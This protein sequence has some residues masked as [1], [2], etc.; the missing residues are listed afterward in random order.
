LHVLE[1][2]VAVAIATGEGEQDVDD[3][4][5]QRRHVPATDIP[6]TGIVV[7]SLSSR[8]ATSPSRLRPAP[9]KLTLEAK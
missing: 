1:N 9:T 3:G 6:V 4:G 7:K 5:R 8:E 2:R